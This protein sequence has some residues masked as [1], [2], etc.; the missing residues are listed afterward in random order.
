MLDSN[1]LKS[2]ALNIVCGIV[3]AIIIGIFTSLWKKSRY[4]CEE[5]ISRDS[6]RIPTQDMSSYPN[7]IK[8]KRRSEVKKIIGEVFF[9]TFT[10]LIILASFSIPIILNNFLD[11]NQV[12]LNQAKYVGMYLPEIPMTGGYANIFVWFIVLILYVPIFW[13]SKLMTKHLWCP[14]VSIFWDYNE[15]LDKMGFLIF[16]SL[17]SLFISACVQWLFFDTEFLQALKNV[18]ILTFF[19]IVFAFSQ[20][21]R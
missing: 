14:L 20:N 21:R 19:A 12:Y 11:T 1:D 8:A 5:G 13:L 4:K 7:D 6:A 3:T 15:N 2:I 16:I 9:Y 17:K 18:L 10:Y